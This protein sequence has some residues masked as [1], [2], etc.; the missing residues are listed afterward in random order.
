MQGT[1]EPQN[2]N[3]TENFE[4]LSDCVFAFIEQKLRLSLISMLHVL[5]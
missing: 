5:I 1:V 2:F 4:D 3:R